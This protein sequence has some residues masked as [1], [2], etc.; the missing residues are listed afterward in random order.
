VAGL[1]RFVS[2][3]NGYSLLDRAVEDEVVPACEAFGL[4]LLPYFPLEYGLL[5]GKYQRGEAAPPGSRAALDPE[6]SQW[7]RDA[8]W[9]RIEALT[10]YASE[11]DLTLLDVAIAGLAAQPAVGSVISGATR[12]EQVRAN[13][14]AL[15]WQPT[16]EDLVELDEV[17]G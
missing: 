14:A 4:G 12:G 7:L 10:A 5:T 9:D 8:E 13:A 1:E 15:R 3:Q 6:R 11:R 16:A 17:T 2:A